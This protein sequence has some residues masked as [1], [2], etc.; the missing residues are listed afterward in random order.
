MYEILV[1]LQV[2]NNALYQE[3]RDAMLP[4]L[5]EYG[6]DFGYD[7]AVSEVLITQSRNAIN[8][9]FTIHFPDEATSECFF[10]SRNYLEAKEKYFNKAVESTTIIA[11]YHK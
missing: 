10:I 3:Y 7:F 9:V 1:G 11:Q 4:I 8:R 2:V 5:K 6:G